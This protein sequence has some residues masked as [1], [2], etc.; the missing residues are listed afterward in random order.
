MEKLIKRLFYIII[1]IAGCKD[2]YNPTVKNTGYNYLVVEG[3]IV[4]G[5]T[6]VIHLTRTIAL[7]D[8]SVIHPETNAAITVESEDG[9]TYTLENKFN[10]DYYHPFLPITSTKKYRVHILTADGK[11][12][13]SEYVPVKL[14]PPID[15]VSWKFDNTGGINVYVNTHDPTNSTQYYRWKYVSC[16]EHRSK[17]SSELIYENGALRYRNPEEE[18]YRCWNINTSGDIFIGSTAALSSDVVF[19]KKV[20]HIE[21]RSP[22]VRWVYS[23]LVTQ[24][25]LTKEAFEYWQNLEQNTEQMGTV[26]DPQPFAEFGNIH[27]ITDPSEPV[28]GFISACSTQQQ[29]LY[30]FYLQ[31]HYPYDLPDCPLVSVPGYQINEVFSGHMFLPLRY[32]PFGSVWAYKT[33]CLDCRL[34]GGTN[35]KPPYMP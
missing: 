34:Q 32:G 21:Y 16:W 24:Y 9:E 12:F 26:F 33:E 30:I 8:T 29:R 19:E 7:S 28:L 27:C 23:I 14:T 18:I 4:V 1:L 22:E 35:S 3:N 2:A 11:E 6:T 15:S 5:D 10:G 17:D 13:A 20:A 31:V 25:A